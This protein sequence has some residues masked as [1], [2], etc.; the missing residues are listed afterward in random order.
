MAR[1]GLLSTIAVSAT[2]SFISG[3]APSPA[4]IA[5]APVHG[6]T[7]AFYVS[8][9]IFVAGALITGLLYERGVPE[10]DPSAEPVLV[11]G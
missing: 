9:A 1:S 5:Q 4:L 3:K 6:Y 7:V 8:A 10:L 11:G 2:T